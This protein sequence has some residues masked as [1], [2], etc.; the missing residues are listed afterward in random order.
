MKKLL[1]FAA[2]IFGMG[3]ETTHYNPNL[4]LMSRS[5]TEAAVDSYTMNKKIYDGFMNRLDVSG[6]L[7]NSK[8]VAALVD[9]RARIYQWTPEMYSAE[10]AKAEEGLAQKIE[11]FL[12]FFVPEPKEDD[13]HKATTKWKI[14]LDVN[15]KRYEGKSTRLKTLLSELVVLYPHHTRFGTPYIV[16]FPVSAREVEAFPSKLVL[17]GPPGSTTLEFNGVK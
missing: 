3:C 9:E 7:H 2:L 13:L 11:I 16:E 10:K 15:G 17:T 8:V 12:S 14:F 5:D 1:F 6:T 4:N